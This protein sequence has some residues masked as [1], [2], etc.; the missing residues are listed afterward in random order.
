MTPLPSGEPGTVPDATLAGRGGM[1][2][3]SIYCTLAMRMTGFMMYF[4]F[5]LPLP[6]PV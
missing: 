3:D 5:A 6:P 4:V 1:C 2:G